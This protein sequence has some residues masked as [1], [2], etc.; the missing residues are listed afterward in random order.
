MKA[1]SINKDPPNHIC[2]KNWN[3]TSTSM[4][5]DIIVEGFRQSVPMHNII[6]H[7]LTGDGDSSVLKKII[8]SKPYGLDTEVKKIECTNHILRNYIN[9]IV[10]IA[11]RRKSSS[12]IVVPGELRKMLKERR[13]K[14]R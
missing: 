7:K 6:Y 10:D 4:E 9:R 11:S 12:G 5:S 2:Y 8:L 1:K 13:L 3:S 14:L